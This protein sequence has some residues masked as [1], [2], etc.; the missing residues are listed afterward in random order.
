MKSKYGRLVLF[1]AVATALALLAGCAA[2]TTA[3]R[4]K[5]LDVQT[6]MSDTIFLDP[7][8]PDQRS[9]FVQVRNT[10]DKPFDI[11]GEVMSAL[12][13]KGYR[14]V[15]DP[16]QANYILQANVL[17][18]GRTDQS[19]LENATGMG[20]GGIAAGAAAGALLGGS[21]AWQGAAVGGL[22]MGAAEAVTGSL[23]QVV[24]YAAITDVQISERVKGAVSEEF[25]STMKQGSAQTYTKQRTA[26]TSNVKKY[27]T[28]IASSA[29]KVN[30]EFPEADPYLRQG[31]VQAISGMF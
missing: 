13:S 21:R 16:N 15:S 7:V 8:A 10:S 23:V 27:Q 26:S 19:A 12:M 20:F 18:V 4:Y 14:V 31:L 1:L 29:R 9:I 11:Q 2:T 3:L 30:L 17:A 28:R 5:D 22:A 24:W 6:K 25:S